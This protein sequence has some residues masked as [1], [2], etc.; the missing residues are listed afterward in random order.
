MDEWNDSFHIN[1]T[2]GEDAPIVIPISWKHLFNSSSSRFF[3]LL[4][5]LLIIRSEWMEASLMHHLNVNYP[6]SFLL[7]FL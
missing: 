1:C 5:F 6:Q 4:S 3:F 2:T 7:F